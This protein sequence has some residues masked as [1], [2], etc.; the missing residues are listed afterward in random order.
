MSTKQ[1]VVKTETTVQESQVDTVD[2]F[3]KDVE[4]L[5]INTAYVDAALEVIGKYLNHVHTCKDR[6]DKAVLEFNARTTS[7]ATH[8]VCAISEGIKR[9]TLESDVHGILE[10]DLKASAFKLDVSLKD[11]TILNSKLK[12]Q[13]KKQKAASPTQLTSTE[14]AIILDDKANTVSVSVAE[15]EDI[16]I[17]KKG[18]T[19]TL[20]KDGE[21]V[22]T[23]PIADFGKKKWRLIAESIIQF[24]KNIGLTIKKYA[25]DKPIS[26][27]KS[28]FNRK[29]KID[30]AQPKPAK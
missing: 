2:I 12:A 17:D 5:V 14:E 7:I 26:G 21:I 30:K 16:I 6:N 23:K 4:D 27:I 22:T 1:N 11:V 20:L 10:G 9:G 28:L 29:D 25:W 15:G 19:I 24:I 3:N 18:G 8:L 13:V